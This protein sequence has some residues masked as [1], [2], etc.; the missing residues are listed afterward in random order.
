MTNKEAKQ[1]IQGW[2]DHDEVDGFE[3]RDALRVAIKALYWKDIMDS[4][5]EAIK[6]REDKET[7]GVKPEWIVRYPEEYDEW[8]YG[9]TCGGAPYVISPSSFCEIRK[10]LTY[11]E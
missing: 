5:I 3:F 4:G 9:F 6:E 8:K 11:D 2:L 7:L 1:I 10:D